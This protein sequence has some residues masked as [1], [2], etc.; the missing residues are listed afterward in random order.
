M[1]IEY[2]V[3]TNMINVTSICE[4]MCIFNGC[5]IIPGSDDT[6]AK[7][8]SDPLPYTLKSIFITIGI[9]ERMKYSTKSDIYIFNDKVYTSETV[10]EILRSLN[11]EEKLKAIQSTL[12]LRYGTFEEEYPEQRMA[13]RYLK[14][15]EKVLEIGG[16]I[17]RNS[18]VIA[19]ILASKGNSDMVVLE[20][21]SDIYPQLKEN[22]DLN[23]L[24]IHVEN[25]ALSRRKLIQK[26][27]DTIESEVVLPGYIPVKTMTFS[28]LEA[29]YGITFDT[30]V[31][32]CEGAFYYI[33]QDMPEILR[34]IKLIIMENDYN[35]LE[36]KIYLNNVLR[37]NGFRVDYSESG[38]WGP[39]QGNFFEVW[40]R[41]S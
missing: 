38:G 16:N 13:V 34:N 35:I 10:P 33:V 7:I 25:S 19:S 15:A 40:V 21:N 24:K 29:K 32:D 14:G 28:E 36:R 9:G 22:V 3:E 11:I 2:G 27:W 31:L 39:C 23:G 8:F 20:S 41:T 12:K 1:K 30:L 26:G 4:S 17:G 37:S 6:R 18:L 5:M